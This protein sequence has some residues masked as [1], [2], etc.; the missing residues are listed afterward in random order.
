MSELTISKFELP[1]SKDEAE[2]N[3]EEEFEDDD[4][5]EEWEDEEV[6]YI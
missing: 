3:E 4:E 5:D 6:C 1:P 2:Y